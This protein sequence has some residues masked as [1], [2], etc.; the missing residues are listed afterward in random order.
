[1]DNI[2]AILA[3]DATMPIAIVGIAGRFPGDA[4][5]PQKLW[6]LIAKAHHAWS[7]VPKDRYNV[8]AFYH[9]YPER[10]GGA[11]CRGGHFLKQDVAVFDAPFFSISPKEAHALDP[12]QR[13]ALEVAYESLENAGMKIEDIAGSA[14]GCYMSTF[15][16][17]Y[18]IIRGHDNEDMPTYESNGNSLSMLSNRVSW[19]FD[20]KG[21]SVSVDTACSSSL[22]GLHLAC[23]SIRAGET[24]SAIVGATNLILTPECAVGLSM[25]HFLSPDSKSMTFDDRANGYARG[26]GAAAVVIKP[27]AHA[28]R[29]GDVIRAVIRNTAV[30]QDG[31]TP[32]VTLPSAAA[33]E[34]LIKSAYKNAGLDPSETNYFE[35]HGTGTAAGDPIETSVIAATFGA[36][37]SPDTPLFIGSIKT[38]I[39]HME[40]VAG[41]AGLVKTVHVLEKGQIPASLWFEKANPKIPLQEWNLRVP[42]KLEPWPT[43][44]LRRASVNS[45]GYGGTNA[46]A[47]LDDAHSYLG[48]RGLKGAHNTTPPACNIFDVAP[49]NNS[50]PISPIFSSASP[51]STVTSVPDGPKNSSTPRLLVW[52]SNEQAG[53]TRVAATIA[54]Y[55]KDNET[56]TKEA[57]DLLLERLASTLSTRRSKLAW[58]SSAVASTLTEAIN[59]LERK[60]T[61]TRTP[62][63]PSPAVVFAFTGQGAQWFAMGRELIVGCPQFRTS[64]EDASA[65]LRTL[66]CEWDLLREIEASELDSKINEPQI[67]HPACTSL[68]V[69]LVNLFWSWGVQ[70]SVI[71]GHSGGEIAA[72][73]AT[74]AISREAAWK[75]AYFRGLLSAQL[76]K[77]GS[78]M[79][80]SLGEEDV[81][82]YFAAAKSGEVTVAC[83]N[84]PASVTLSG[85]STAIVEI[86]KALEEAGVFCRKLMVTTAYHTSHMSE[87]A[88]PYFR[89][90]EGMSCESTS[91]SAPTM[92]SSVTGKRITAKKLANPRHWVDNMIRPVLFRQ[93]VEEAVDHLDKLNTPYLFLEIGPHGALQNLIKQIIDP[94]D[95]GKTAHQP[96]IT[97]ALR[98]KENAI[99]TSLE[100]VSVLYHQGYPV[101]ISLVNKSFGTAQSTCVTSLVDLPPFAWNH[102]TRFWYESP[103]SLAYRHR[104]LPRHDMLGARCEFSSQAEPAWRN[105]LRLSEIPWLE[106]HKVQNTILFPFAGMIA[107]AVEAARQT[108]DKDKTFVGVQLREVST[109]AAIIIPTEGAVETKFQ[110]RPWRTGSKSRN[111][112]WQE[113]S[114]ASRTQ[115][116]SW[117]QNCSGL[118]AVKY[119]LPPKPG[120][121]DE[122]ALIAETHRLEY[123]RLSKA[124]LVEG[125]TVS[126]YDSFA[127]AGVEMGP[128]FKNIVDFHS[129]EKEAHYSLVTPDTKAWMPAHYESVNIIHPAILDSVIQSFFTVKGGSAATGITK[130]RIPK[131]AGSIFISGNIPTEPG[132]QFRGYTKYT[133]QFFNETIGS[134]VI[135]D[136]TWTR[137]FVVFEGFKAV[138]LAEGAMAVSETNAKAQQEQRL[139]KLGSRLTWEVDVESLTGTEALKFFKPIWE[140]PPPVD[141]H[142]DYELEKAAFILGKRVLRQFPN[143]EDTKDF[144][145]PHRLLY[146]YLKRDHD[147]AL[148]G[149]LFRQRDDW[150][151]DDDASDDEF[152][153]RMA[154]ETID[155]KMLCRV[156]GKLPEIFR[157]EIEALEV[158]RTDNLLTDYYRHALADERT[159]AVTCAFIKHLSHKRPLRVLEVG[160]GTGGATSRILPA[161]GD[162]FSRVQTYTYTDISSAFFEAAS[163]DF[164]AWDSI[165]EY[166]VLDLEKDPASQ[167]FDV[168]SYDL[169]VAFQVLHATSCI[170]NT[171]AY[172]WK[173][174]KPGGTLLMSE[175]TGVRARA[176][177]IFGTLPGWWLGENDGRKW[178]PL[179]KDEQWDEQLRGQG[180]GGI[181]WCVH[182]RDTEDY[183]CSVII[184]EAKTPDVRPSAA[185]VIIISRDEQTKT[186]LLEKLSS[187]LEDDDSVGSVEKVTL[188]ELAEH[189]VTGKTCIAALEIDTPLLTNIES[190][191]F[192]TVKHMILE[193]NRTLWLTRGG[194]VDC[195]NPE[196]SLMTGLSR[197]ICSEVPE[198]RLTTVDLDPQRSDTSD[199]LDAEMV[200]QVLGRSSDDLGTAETPTSALEEREFAVRNG[201]L[202]IPRIYPDKTISE[203][204][205]PNLHEDSVTALQPLKQ[206]DYPLRLELK[207]SGALDTFRFV[208][209]DEYRSQPLGSDDVEIEI[210]AVGLGLYDLSCAMGRIWSPLLGVEFSGVVTRVGSNVTKLMTGDKVVSWSPGW[211]RTYLRTRADTVQKMPDDMTYEQGASMPSAYAAAVYCIFHL[212]RLEKGESILIHSASGVLGRVAIDLAK[213]IGAE[214]FVTVSSEAK[215]RL[216]VD[217]YGVAEDHVFSSKDSGDFAQGIRRLTN[218][219]GVDVVINSSVGETLRQTWHCIAAFGRFIELGVMDIEA[220]TGL[221]MAPFA[222]N[223]TFSSVNLTSLALEKPDKFGALIGEALRYY[224]KGIVRLIDPI[225]VMKFS[226]IE[227]AFRIMNMK[228]YTGKIVLKVVDDDL[229]PVIPKQREAVRLN[230]DATYLLPGGLGGLGR[231]LAS[232]MV[233]RGAKH[234]V[235]TS[236]NGARD[237]RAKQ[238]LENVENEG[239]KAKSFASDISD[240]KQF[241][242]V[243]HDLEQ[244]GFPPIRGVVTFAMQLQDAFFE[245]MTAEDFNAALPPKVG[246]TRNMHNFLPKDLDFF[247]CISSCGGVVGTWPQ[248]NYNAGNT[249]QDAI[250]RHRRAHGLNATSI[251]LGRIAGIGFV[252][253][254]GDLPHFMPIGAPPISEKQYLATVEAA[255]RCDQISAQAIIGLSTGGLLKHISDPNPPWFSEARFQPLAVLDTQGHGADTVVAKA[256]DDLQAKLPGVTSMQE[257]QDA[258]CAA[259][260]RKLARTLLLA[261]EDIDSM[262][263]VNSYGVDS[264]VAVEIRTWA[265]KEAHSSVSVF[266]ILGN[267][268]MMDLAGVIAAK[269]RIVPESLKE[270]GDT[271]N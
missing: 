189:D 27:L 141:E 20:L 204:L 50:E 73:Y 29:D 248:G 72:A 249:Y 229:V 40:G 163:E 230:P 86:E 124:K 46:H 52:S 213:Y 263:V 19:F 227:E 49:H 68:Q 265:A 16:R 42:T 99:I 269:S 114:I 207:T 166:K 195:E 206:T 128:T 107:M 139:R 172:C 135:S 147:L 121:V 168:G 104:E 97:T 174:L 238:L 93:S 179:L 215:K 144:T 264:L 105:Y 252:A 225:Q 191:Q 85:D 157:R 13:M 255:M 150:L 64:L 192:N 119:L 44:G 83:I 37:R 232:W 210:K 267:V 45:F 74:Q 218:G 164:K 205:E 188:S 167:G 228:K 123:A 245:N 60:I 106:H 102:T 193:S 138:E 180:F 178:G 75:I 3:Q 159:P 177:M 190:R 43:S 110:V 66:G 24:D 216:L 91:M 36:H 262:R 239:V 254:H 235:F 136:A 112:T 56:T 217:Q 151:S 186:S 161:L 209:D 54:S 182:D 67:S 241:Q 41:L 101:D 14:M 88:E 231:S 59:V 261:V 220:N 199:A 81:K 98:R 61:P 253:E 162:A 200:L 160:A 153:A 95:R 6:E 155:G 57:S 82:P 125:N 53:I 103:A 55:L 169:V 258:V 130:P 244:A 12:Q 198:I 203:I 127:N 70:P 165:M 233:Q 270:S 223:A 154:A 113:F 65:Y 234:L 247:I 260:M 183:Y 131:Y 96:R 23:Q 30:N 35:A 118:L 242:A 158:M 132:T 5:D 51:K 173:M 259:L 181:K 87:L 268:P 149:K 47:I 175:V 10:Q 271:L 171:L 7:E 76:T 122:D 63:S 219:K 38:N 26:E 90:L 33:Q 84:S 240:E 17:D 201:V 48:S 250:A 143:P 222:K 11:N 237:P 243:L 22:V 39:G 251:D 71:V 100:A 156:G 257:A 145:E 109:D 202:H 266:E 31:R 117:T 134:V 176:P 92:F 8:D 62:S 80:V 224:E 129:G 137:P 208:P 142:L 211:Y 187:L 25:Q 108:A 21:P 94:L 194:A 170:S 184:S 236:R 34:A 32:G 256:D 79:A 152:L 116:G 197:T 212:A 1:M 185:D 221:D 148:D 78:M 214:I 69:A 4:T 28:L 126:L 2:T 111:P 89:A 140:T 246:V 18:S 226:Q 9:P 77:N 146:Q 115:E 133:D 120:F 58:V 15:T 196:M